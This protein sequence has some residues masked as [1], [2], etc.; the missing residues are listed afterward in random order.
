MVAIS[1]WMSRCALESRRF[2]TTAPMHAKVQPRAQSLCA[3]GCVCMLYVP[4]LGPVVVPYSRNQINDQS[5]RG[6]PQEAVQTKRNQTNLTTRY[7]IVKDTIILRIAQPQAT[8]SQCTHVARIQGYARMQPVIRRW[9]HSY[10]M[11][12]PDCAYLCRALAVML[13]TTLLLP[14]SGVALRASMTT[15]DADGN[16]LDHHKPDAPRSHR[17]L[18]APHNFFIFKLNGYCRFC[19]PDTNDE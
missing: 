17:R 4:D 14:A 8:S 1:Q 13:L 18:L 16:V 9:Q 10:C 3:R 5:S 15:A 19:P 12:R 7:T 11:H 2:E 6:Q